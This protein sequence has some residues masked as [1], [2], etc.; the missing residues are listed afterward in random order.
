MSAPA[1]GSFP[2]AE[3]EALR[4]NAVLKRSFSIETIAE[5]SEQGKTADFPGLATGLLGT[6]GGESD[7]LI[8]TNM[9]EALLSLA[10][11]ASP[12][13]RQQI[14]SGLE[15]YLPAES[16]PYLARPMVEQAIEDL[17]ANP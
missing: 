9:V 3:D 1:Q 15:R 7:Y 11:R 17:R 6:L 5:R 2:D 12:N 8:R 10:K 14:V 4:E 13:E 16:D